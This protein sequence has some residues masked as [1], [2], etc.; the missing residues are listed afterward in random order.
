MLDNYL[1][2]DIE[3]VKVFFF[4]IE[5]QIDP[6]RFVKLEKNDLF[7]INKNKLITKNYKSGKL[8]IK[9]K[10]INKE[11]IDRIDEFQ[12]L[13]SK[14]NTGLSG[15]KGA[16]SDCIKKLTTFLEE[17]KKYTFDDILRVSKYYVENY[18]QIS[19]YLQ[20]AN[21]FIKKNGDSRL[22]ELLSE[23]N[24]DNIKTSDYGSQII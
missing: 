19:T 10:S 2:N 1:F 8:E 9:E 15:K 13:W 24:D 6:A 16:K 21:Y 5:N 20:R 3:A 14:T 7:I 18:P 23:E 4:C 12:Y 11:V 22:E 17:N